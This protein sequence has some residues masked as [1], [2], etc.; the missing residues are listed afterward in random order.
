MAKA[1]KNLKRKT[2]R[3]K[4]ADWKHAFEPVKRRILLKH[5]L[6]FFSAGILSGLAAALLLA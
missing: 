2:N 4:H 1:M 6:H 5:M 3:W